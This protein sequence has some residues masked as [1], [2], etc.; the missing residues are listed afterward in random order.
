MPRVFA[1]AGDS[2][3]MTRPSMPLH[4]F[5][6]SAPFDFII[7]DAEAKVMSAKLKA[8]NVI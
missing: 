7:A 4:P 8:E 6:L 3:G 5:L 2:E 1:W